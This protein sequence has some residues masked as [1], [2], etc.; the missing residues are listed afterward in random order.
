MPTL[1]PCLA[2]V[3]WSLAAAVWA[4]GPQLGQP[5]TPDETPSLVIWPDGRGLPAGEGSVPA[6][7]TLYARHCL[8]CHG[9]DGRDGLNDTLVGG[10]VGPDQVPAQR[11]IGSY[12]P[13][14][15]SLYD[16][17]RRA[18]PYQSPGS[19]TDEEVYALVAYLLY[20]NQIIEEDTVLDA[21]RLAEIE[22]PNRY[23]FHSRFELP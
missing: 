18:M 21:E 10:Q 7:H 13:Y 16:Y 14:A 17:I 15:T 9:V 22:M 8:A 19:L 4:A 6:G 5:I 11:T 12:W 1:R 23:R 3:L 20:L 2:L